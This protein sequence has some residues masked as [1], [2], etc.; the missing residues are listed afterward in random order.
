MTVDA[1][2]LMIVIMGGLTVGLSIYVALRFWWHHRF[3]K[4]GARKLTRALAGMLIGE[5][6]IGLVTLTFGILEWTGALPSIAI[7]M[8][9][10]LRVIA[11]SATSITTLHLYLV[12]EDLHR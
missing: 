8:Q 7:E 1:L 10:A 2:T 3:L 6:I 11:F 12:V 9:S 4:S 5:A